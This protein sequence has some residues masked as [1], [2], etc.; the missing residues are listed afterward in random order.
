MRTTIDFDEPILRD[1]KRLQKK[2]NKTLSQLVSELVARGMA[3]R[4]E[5][6]EQRPFK[7]IARPM[8]ARVDL[9][10]KDELYRSL[11][12]PVDQAARKFSP[13]G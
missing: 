7:W 10:D 3:A 13:R 12:H 11:D 4:N 1:L 8:R 2:E 6:K 5:R 9:R